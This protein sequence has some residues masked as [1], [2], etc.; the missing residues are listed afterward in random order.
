MAH[1]V[2]ITHENVELIHALSSVFYLP[3]FFI[4]WK[5]KNRVEHQLVNVLSKNCDKAVVLL[6]PVFAISESFHAAL[7][8]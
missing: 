4:F 3:Q 6:G 7:N 5:V 1:H 8:Y 2:Y